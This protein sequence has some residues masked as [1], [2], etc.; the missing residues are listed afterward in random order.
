MQKN[1][2]ET[3]SYIIYKYQKK[4]RRPKSKDKTVKL[5]YVNIEEK[6]HDIVVG[7]DFLV[8]MLKTQKT[9]EKQRRQAALH[10]NLQLTKD[11]QNNG[12]ASDRM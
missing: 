8:I 11:Y 12:N 3:L 7:N 9:K 4:W 5:L 10:Q 6:L 1:E 2:G